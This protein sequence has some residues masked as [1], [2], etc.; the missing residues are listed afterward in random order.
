MVV[1]FFGSAHG[2][3][4]ETSTPAK[5]VTG[6]VRIRDGVERLNQS[7]DA[8]GRGEAKAELQRPSTEEAFAAKNRV[9][10]A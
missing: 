1:R 5:Q 6:D 8:V 10:L 7:K 3:S 2:S 9:T 4:V